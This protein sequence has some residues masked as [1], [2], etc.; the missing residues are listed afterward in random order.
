MDTATVSRAANA[1][2]KMGLISQ[3]ASDT[4]ARSN[5]L[6]LTP[7]GA[8]AHDQLAAERMK[9]QEEVHSH[10]SPIEWLALLAILDK[11]DTI[12]GITEAS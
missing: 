8:A 3:N 1:L 11:L 7:K 5:I 10:F 2:V 9:L 4:D 12:L 6:T